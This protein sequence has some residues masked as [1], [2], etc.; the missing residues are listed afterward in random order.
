MISKRLTTA[1]VTFIIL[2]TSQAYGAVSFVQPRTL[3][4]GFSNDGTVSGLAKADFNGDGRPDIAVTYSAGGAG[5][6]GVLLGAG[7]GRFKAPITINLPT[8]TYNTVGIGIAAEDFD[9]DS[10]PDL[11]VAAS[12]FHG[13]NNVFFFKGRGD[14]TFNSFVAFALSAAGNGAPYHL[15]SADLDNNSIPD[16]I[17]LNKSEQKIAVLLGNG[18]G[19]F[20]APAYYPTG[21]NPQDIAIT[22]LSGDGSPDIA[23][24]SYDDRKITV[25]INNGNGIFSAT[26]YDGRIQITGVHIGDFNKDGKNDLVITGAGGPNCGSNC[27]AFVPGKGDGTFDPIPDGNF[28]PRIEW[29]GENYSQKEVRDINADGN[30]DIVFPVANGANEVFVG[31]GNGDGTFTSRVYVAAATTTGTN[32]TNVDGGNP[33]C[34]LVE[35][36]DGDGNPDIVVGESSNNARNG[37]LSYLPG[38]SQGTFRSPRLMQLERGLSSTTKSLAAGDFDNDGIMDAVVITDALDFMK[39]NGDGSF[40]P[41]TVALGHIGGSGEFYNSLKAA[42][43]DGDNN[44]DVAWLATAGAQGG[45]LPRNI[46]AFGNSDGTF[47]ANFIFPNTDSWAGRNISIADFNNDGSPDIAVWADNPGGDN[48]RIEVFLYNP[49]SPR[50]FAS[51]AGFTPL[52]LDPLPGYPGYALGT[53]DF[54]GDG[55]HDVVAHSRAGGS[56]DRLLFFGGNGDG[57]FA[58][59]TAA[60]Y[61]LPEMNDFQTADLDGDLNLDL[62]GFGGNG[63]YV[64]IGNGDGT[65]AAPVLYGA[66]PYPAEMRLVD[67]DGDGNLDIAAVTGQSAVVFSGRGDGTFGP[68]VRLAT[69]NVSSFTLDIADLNG[70]GKTDI[71]A[72]QNS[73]SRYSVTPLINDSGPR[74]DL[75]IATSRNPSSSDVGQPVTFTVLV[76]NDGPDTATGVVVELIVPLNGMISSIIAGQGSCTG[77][78]TASCTIGDL[79]NGAGTTITVVAVPLVAGMPLWIAVDGYSTS[80]ESN[81]VNNGSSVST[82]INAEWIK[83][84][85][86]KLV[87]VGDR[88]DYVIRYANIAG[89]ALDNVV[90]VLDLPPFKI[91]SSK[92]GIYHKEHNQVFWKLGTVPAGYSGDLTATVEVP[93]GIAGHT[94]FHLSAWIGWSGP[95]VS[96]KDI[97]EYLTYSPRTVASRG[98]LNAGDIAAL[99][100]GSP[101]VQTLY[102]QALAQGY[103]DYGVGTFH[104]LS[105]SSEEQR[106][107]MINPSTKQVAA[108][109]VNAAGSFLEYVEADK[110]A[111]GGSDGAVAFNFNSFSTEIQGDWAKIHSPSYGECMWGCILPKIPIWLLSKYGGDIVSKVIGGSKCSGCSDQN[112]SDCT[113][114]LGLIEDLPFVGEAID[115]IQ[116][117]EDCRRCADQVP[118]ANCYRCTQDHTYCTKGSWFEQ[119]ILGQDVVIYT[120]RCTAGGIW[121]Y[122]TE[123]TFC[124][125]CAHGQV[126]RNGQCSCCQPQNGESCDTGEVVTAHDPNLLSGPSGDVTRGQTLSYIIEYQNEGAGTA[127]DVFVTGAVSPYLDETTLVIQNGGVYHAGTRTILWSAGD[128]TAGQGGTVTFTAGVKSNAPIGAEIIGTASVHFPSVPEITPTNAIVA[129][130]KPVSATPQTVSATAGVPVG[131]TLS[132][133]EPGG[134]P[135]SFS[136]ASQPSRGLLTGTPPNLTYTSDLELSGVDSFAFVADNGTTVSDPATVTIIISPSPADT[137]PPQ[138]ISVTPADSSNIAVSVQQFGPASY[139][140]LVKAFFNKPLDPAT[141]T[142]GTFEVSAGGNPVAGAVSYDGVHN[143]VVFTPSSPLSYA[144]LYSA[145]VG[146]G[147][148][149]AAGNNLAQPYTWNFQTFGNVAINASPSLSEFGTIGTHTERLLTVTVYN[150]GADNLTIDTVSIGGADSAMFS[151]APD[152]CSASVIVPGGSCTVTVRFYPTTI[153]PKSATLD[154]V[155]S[156]SPLSSS[157]SGSATLSQWALDVSLAGNGGGIVTSSPAGISCGAGCSAIYDDGTTVALTAV[158]NPGS[159]FGGWFG[160]C[161]GNVNPCEVLMEGPRAVQAQFNLLADFTATPLSGGAPLVVSFT[162]Q[163]SAS[164][165]AWLWIYGDGWSDTLENPIHVYRE[166]G[167]Y[168]VSLVSWGDGNVYSITRSNY[169][170]V[171]DCQNKARAGNGTFTPYALIQDAYANAG[172]GEFVDVLGIDMTESPVF[173]LG[174]DITLRGGWDCLFST[175]ALL[176]TGLTGVLTITDGSVTVEGLII[177]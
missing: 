172:S 35:D 151:L 120:N 130:V 158:P 92:D 86:P 143:S 152:T 156:S 46:V 157:L 126:C 20:G 73:G 31:L 55:N 148:T 116:C 176:H 104:V 36:F 2:F 22:D 95:L 88:I 173:N 111:V 34:L 159:D 96:P 8:G 90:I 16:I 41:S 169:V 7:N 83:L 23:A 146:T 118:G 123:K 6:I 138:V 13:S 119:N 124:A 17:T 102:N 142:G 167:V 131:I 170:A 60:S 121:A 160:N 107:L 38:A 162:D 5:Y 127:Y 78:N 70:D 135:L 163:S 93:W 110:Y 153:G 33:T 155:S 11:A 112:P 114:C 45:P 28:T 99:L 52:G 18:D 81:F 69:G 39:G 108:V 61:D 59:P 66:G 177:Q 161:S 106:I 94:P 27:A 174:T 50:T 91:R 42:D 165:S 4:L 9:M 171:V 103:R 77:S 122:G 51:A 24:G 140:P 89:V 43:F 10:V 168:S 147:L 149:D 54:D 80:V 137:T 166:P 164:P 47:P 145:T 87:V 15:E 1:L 29:L 14:G 12:D 21:V 100:G 30:P 129:V 71:I 75:R 117:N 101:A 44:L 175:N 105:D 57:T 37:S 76:T 84:Y 32:S 26:Q 150:S 49:S 3:P 68:A 64:F 53:G 74:S 85:S 62:I 154:I 67:L 134:Q 109:L 139:Y 128:L 82:T 113:D 136:I 25:F 40:A 125:L 58:A 133:S 144:T 115:I 63:A 19:T 65:F 79:A 141:V 48:G 98:P 56:P 72:G 132:G 97:T